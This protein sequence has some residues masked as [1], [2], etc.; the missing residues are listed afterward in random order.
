MHTLRPDTHWR[1]FWTAIAVMVRC[2]AGKLNGAP[3][4]KELS[5]QKLQV[6]VLAPEDAPGVKIIQKGSQRLEVELGAVP[7]FTSVQIESARRASE[8]IEAAN[9]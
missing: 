3:W 8:V 1:R 4:P 2:I 7:V 5:R 6:R 9:E